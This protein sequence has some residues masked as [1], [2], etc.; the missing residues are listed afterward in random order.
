MAS[1]PKITLLSLENRILFC[2]EYADLWQQFFQ[3]FYSLHEESEIS[4]EME[5]EFENIASVLSV[6]HYKFTQLCGQ[7]MKD[8]DA[9]LEILCDAVSLDQIRQ[10]PEANRSKLDI[11]WHTAFIDMNKAL[12]KMFAEL[13]PKRLE[14]L[15]QMQNQEEVQ[16][17]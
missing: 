14:A 15:Q 3:M 5:T 16:S 13:P 9:V 17:A 11:A 4:P 2:Q 1:Q 7:Y 12:G 8:A 6:N 10:M